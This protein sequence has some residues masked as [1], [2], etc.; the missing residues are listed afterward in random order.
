MFYTYILK[1]L[2]DRKL[3][4]GS[5][6]DLKKRVKEHNTGL[7]ESTKNRKP[8]KLIYYE[9]YLIEN[10][11]RKREKNLKLRANALT[12]LKRRIKE[13]LKS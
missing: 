1:S 4:I 6:N 11:A 13:S 3:Y 12:Q 9:A 8:F 10:E 5:T 7:V 2:I